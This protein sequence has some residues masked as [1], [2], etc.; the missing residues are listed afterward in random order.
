MDYESLLKRAWNIVLNNK[1]LIVLGALASLGSGGSGGG[2]G[3]GGNH[4]TS[5]GPGTIT[6]PMPGQEWSVP[7]PD[8]SQLGIPQEYFAIGLT[9]LLVIVVMLIIL[10]V[11]LWVIGRIATGGLIAGV[12]QIVTERET[13]FRLAWNAGWQKGWRL[14]GIDLVPAFPM[15]LG[16]VIVVVM[17]LSMTGGLTSLIDDAG[18]I[19]RIVPENP[20]GL[21]LAAGAILCPAVL[22]S[23]VFGILAT[24]AERACM[25]EDKGIIESYSRGWEIITRNLSPVIILALIQVAI[26]IILGIVLFAPSILMA[27]CCLLW[28]VLWAIG[29]A[30]NAYFSTVW[31]LAWHE[32]AGGEPKEFVLDQAYNV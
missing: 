13:S 30:I 15:L 8:F 27:C 4:S 21:A 29:G 19:T 3:G 2:G 23:L 24:F 18:R 22:F 17:V 31:T 1:Y 20:I 14:I 32:W 5:G 7:L 6:T 26:G 16:L 10:G 11:T 28:P 12:N 9:A 25:L